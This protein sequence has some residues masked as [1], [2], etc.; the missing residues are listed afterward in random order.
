ML[1]SLEAEEEVAC[2]FRVDAEIVDRTL[3]I[4]FGVGGQPSLYELES[5]N[6]PRRLA[7]VGSL[8]SISFA[9]ILILLMKHHFIHLLGHRLDVIDN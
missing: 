1:T 5:V 7:R 3:G 2:V 8:T 6:R 4:G 9:K